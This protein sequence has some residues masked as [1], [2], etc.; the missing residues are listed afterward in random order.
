MFM[1]CKKSL[2]INSY[3][4]KKTFLLFG[5]ILLF[6]SC[7]N[8]MNGG[9]LIEELQK[10]IDYSNAASL[11]IL[12]SPEEGTGSTVPYGEY[13]VKSGYSFKVTFTENTEKYSFVRWIALQ[14]DEEI[15]EG[16]HFENPEMPETEVTISDVSDIRILPY[17]EKRIT[18]ST[19]PSPK[20]EPNGVSRDRSI[21]V[22]FTKKPKSDCFIFTEEELPDEAESIKND[23]GEI[24]AYKLSNLIYFKNISIT[25]ADDISIAEHFLQPELEGTRLTIATNKSNPIDFEDGTALKTVKVALSGNI[26]DENGIS[27]HSDKLWRYQI[28]NTTDDKAAVTISSE[29]GAGSLLISGTKDYSIGQKI[30]LNFTVNPKYVFLYWDYDSSY[31]SV[32]E[33][34]NPS[35]NAVIKEQT[36]S[37]PTQIKAVC[38]PKPYVQNT[39]PTNTVSVSKN[40]PIVITFSQNMTG[41]TNTIKIMQS[42]IN[43]TACFD[44]VCSNNAEG[45]TQITYTLKRDCYTNLTAGI[46]NIVIPQELG[47]QFTSKTGTQIIPMEKEYTYSYEINN[48]TL[49]KAK[50][51]FSCDGGTSSIDKTGDMEFNLDETFTITL[52]VDDNYNF[53]GWKIVKNDA[54]KTPVDSNILYS[55]A[56]NFINTLTVTINAPTAEN[57][58]ILIYPDISEK[59]SVTVKFVGTN[60]SII[61]SEQKTV[62]EGQSFNLSFTVEDD[63]CFKEWQLSNNS[64]IS[65]LNNFISQNQTLT[66]NH[67]DSATPETEVTITA[68]S[69]KRP[70]VLMGTPEYNS[71]GTYLDARIRIFFDQPMNSTTIT[72]ENITVKNIATG[73]DLTDCYNDPIKITDSIFALSAN[74]TK[75]PPAAT[76]VSVEISKNVTGINGASLKENYSW[77]YFLGKD[78]D[79]TPPTFLPNTFEIK[80]VN[81]QGVE[82]DNSLFTDLLDPLTP[83]EFQK[84]FLKSR[85]ISVSAQLEDLESNVARLCIGVKK[86]EDYDPTFSSITPIS[87]ENTIPEDA[88]EIPVTVIGVNA[89]CSDVIIDLSSIIDFNNSY[90][91][92]FYV[93]DNVGNVAVYETSYYLI[94][95]Y[96]APK[97]YNIRENSNGEYDTPTNTNESDVYDGSVFLVT[98]ADTNQSSFDETKTLLPIIFNSEDYRTYYSTYYLENENLWIKGKILELG[99][100]IKSLQYVL[101]KVKTDS[102]TNEVSYEFIEYGDVPFTSEGTFVNIDCKLPINYF[103]NNKAQGVYSISF[104]ATDYAEN[105]TEIIEKSISETSSININSNWFIFDNKAPDPNLIIKSIEAYSPTSMKISSV[106]FGAIPSDFLYL[107]YKHNDSS[108]KRLTI[109]DIFNVQEDLILNEEGNFIVTFR[110]CDLLGNLSDEKIYTIGITSS[111]VR[112]G[113]IYYDDGSITNGWVNTIKNPVG[114]VCW[115]KDPASSTFMQARIWDIKYTAANETYC[116]GKNGKPDYFEDGSIFYDS[117][118]DW[119]Y[120]ISING[121]ANYDFFKSEYYENVFTENSFFTYIENVKRKNT[122]IE[123]YIP[124]LAEIKTMIIPNDKQAILQQSIDLLRAAGYEAT[125]FDD[126]TSD[127]NTVTTLITSEVYEQNYYQVFKSNWLE[128]LENTDA[129]FLQNSKT[130]TNANLHCMAQVTF[131]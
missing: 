50:F 68:I 65:G 111:S 28:T 38:V 10:K 118:D 15:T 42:G 58:R 62:Y 1:F 88:I 35:T 66:L 114:I 76:E 113:S 56:D 94:Q 74:K 37:T 104:T 25:N 128:L 20:Y 59:Q 43:K 89:T 40:T 78:K 117:K 93:E 63:Y 14:N 51:T 80:N 84:F 81:E 109:N 75:L 41:D 57:E 79:E 77:M 127:N 85:C 124:T 26:C 8:F 125:L 131:E 48:T 52:K 9:D 122:N 119:Y 82:W 129:P 45:N 3:F 2:F 91:L 55:Y 21:T 22:E 60:G 4:R 53:N 101:N 126:Y 29:D 112:I 120:H 92:N 100:G 33:K 17:C 6:S 23:D 19:D 110:G 73:A 115:L 116:W 54:A 49:S 30:G 18:L 34:E 70:K 98:A 32:A 67:Q 107:E 97:F 47:Y 13:S 36:G 90:Q 121:R 44:K 39:T 71:N 95:D 11:T 102:D 83:E 105:T 61:P 106:N 96:I 87:I 69:V 16:I 64:L 5:F 12:V 130:A 24:W 31:V 99:S 7:H 46:I 72:K 27:L 86:L 103:A 108:W 123:W